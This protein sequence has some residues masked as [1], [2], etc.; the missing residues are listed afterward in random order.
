M[1]ESMDCE[2]C[3]KPAVARAMIEGA[4]LYVC[5]SCAKHGTAVKQLQQPAPKKPTA[6]MR[7]PEQREELVEQVRPD[8]AKLLR[9]H[10]ERLG[11]TH[12]QYAAKLQIKASTYHHYESGSAL[13]D[14]P[15]ARKLEHVLGTPLVV[16]VRVTSQQV[17]H[18][19]ARGMTLGD[20]VKR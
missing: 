12:E 11:M 6:S 16:H 10:R 2:M 18:D 1:R 8:L 19:E 4:Q 17:K 14:I 13:P 15:T 3:G 9:Q 7:A 20:F 5:G